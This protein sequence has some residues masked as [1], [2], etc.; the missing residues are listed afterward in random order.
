MYPGKKLPSN[1][2][3][4]T[5]KTS[6]VGED[7]SIILNQGKGEYYVRGPADGLAERAGVLF[8]ARK[9]ERARRKNMSNRLVQL[10]LYHLR[11]PFRG[12]FSH[13]AAARSETDTVI[14]AALLADG[15]V[16][17]GEGV[18]R[19]YVTGETVESVL[20]NISDT[21]AGQLE[22]VEPRSY[23]ELLDFV[24][25]LP[26]RN[27]QGQIINSARCCVELALLDVYGKYFG[28]SVSSISGWLGYG[29]F[30]EGGS[31]EEIR[32]SGV[33]GGSRPKRLKRRLRLMRWYGLRDFKLK[34]GYPHDMDNLKEVYRRL[35]GALH[36]REVSLRVDANGAW[37]ID[38]AI[39]MSDELNQ[40]QVCCMEQPLAVDDRSHWF[41]LAEMSVMPLMADESLVSQED[42]EFLMEN[43]LVDFFNIRISKN[44]GL[45]PALHLA[46]MAVSSGLE[47]QLGAM[48]GESGVLAAAGRH[49]LQMVPSVEFTEIS[50]STFLL[51]EELVKRNMR[52]GY[53]G[54]VKPMAGAGL[55]ISIPRKKI[56]KFSVQPSRKIHLA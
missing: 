26:F 4:L 2:E 44:G 9:E 36:N 54:R 1:L 23:A 5:E 15:T 25:K 45:L 17:F 31:L 47:Y 48:V 24:D 29:P 46:E 28:S 33:L 8:T 34:M 3:N 13:A 7:M 16:G 52:F 53:G 20:Y 38:T 18:P 12:R 51:R 35:K 19:E 41:A 27:E 50:Y 10:E 11:L 30:Q 43:N 56:S 49:F 6:D 40:Y 37:D 32:V 42:G 21:L 39:A 22:H 14:A 55:G